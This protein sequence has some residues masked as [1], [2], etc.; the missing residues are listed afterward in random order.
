MYM[1]SEHSLSLLTCDL[2]SIGKSYTKCNFL[3]NLN[4]NMYSKELKVRVKFKPKG[5]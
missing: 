4:P 1:F 2:S 3:E 5:N